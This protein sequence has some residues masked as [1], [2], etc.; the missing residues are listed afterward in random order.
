M[1]EFLETI[2]DILQSLDKSYACADPALQTTM[3]Q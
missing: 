3:L 1:L 2:S